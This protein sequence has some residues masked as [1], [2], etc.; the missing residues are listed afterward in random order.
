MHRELYDL[1]EVEPT[2][3]QDEIKKAYKKLSK[4]HHPDKGGDEEVFKQI[5]EAY[6]IL[7][8]PVN[9]RV[10]D[11]SGQK[12][13]VTKEE[14]MNNLFQ[15]FIIPAIFEIEMTSF[16]RVDIREFIMALLLD[17]IK[18]MKH[19]LKENESNRDKI[20][21][22]TERLSKRDPEV[23]SIDQYFEPHKKNLALQVVLIEEEIEFLKKM[24]MI[25]A[26]Y[27]Y[28]KAQKILIQN[29]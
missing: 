27:D 3:T 29:F 8:D 22:F 26:K 21:L 24:R 1:L 6:E 18:E 10:Y 9:R 11:Q 28:K 13:K 23:E 12:N 7:S 14:R 15:A 5:K 25:F 16:E 20:C 4:K 17:K 19:K 2:A